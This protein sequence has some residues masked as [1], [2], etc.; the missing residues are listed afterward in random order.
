MIRACPVPARMWGS[1]MRFWPALALALAL[2]LDLSGPALSETLMTAEEF[3]AWSTG[4]TLDYFDAGTYWGSEQHLPGRRTVDTD[5]DGQCRKGIWFP[6]D[7]A[8]CFQYPTID[9]QFCWHFWREGD[10]VTAKTVESDPEIAPYA[11]TLSDAP[12]S[13]QGPEVGV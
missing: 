8:I 7:D 1:E 11:V 6:E 10:Q 12:P 13:C 5:G 9:G 2:G 3:E 4:R